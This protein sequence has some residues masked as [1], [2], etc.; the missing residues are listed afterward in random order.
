MRA[1][2]Q[3]QLRDLMGAQAYDAGH[4]AGRLLMPAEAVDLA[5]SGTGRD[6]IAMDVVHSRHE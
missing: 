2:E 3:D 4:Q 6:Q 1:R 5:L